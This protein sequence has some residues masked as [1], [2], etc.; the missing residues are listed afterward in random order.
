MD[1]IS[2]LIL[3]IA[4]II[5][6]W[7][8]GLTL[9]LADFRRV[10]QSPIAVLVGLLNQLI[11]LPLIAFVL[12]KIVPSQ[13]EIAVGIMILS[14]CPGGPTSNLLSLLAKAD[15]A[16]SVSLT[17]L[18]SILTIFTIPFIVNFGLSEFAG[19]SQDIQLDVL[20]TIKTMFLVVI[21][22]MSIGMS[23]RKWKPDFAEKMGKPVR[24]A[25]AVLL[26]LII[27]GIVIKE[28]EH[29]LDYFSRA[30]VL[31]FL[32]NA[33]TMSVGYFSARFFKLSLPQAKTISLESGIQNGTM[34]LAI[35]GGIL[36]N[37]AYGISPA[38]YS[39]IMYFTAGFMIWRMGKLT[40]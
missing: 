32:L 8:M 22:P 21:V 33:L 36:E 13:P 14:A 39:L 4:L 37:S 12:L 16:L 26:A 18:N 31:A 9:V 30:G 11:L 38:V 10:F 17:A 5:T 29:M 1:N 28:R 3:G 19:E 2:T 6:M 27:I 23:I 25:S 20:G 7:G 34:A 40:K 35:A 15:T 24:I